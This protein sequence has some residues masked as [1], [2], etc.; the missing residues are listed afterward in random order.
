MAGQNKNG[1][2]LHIWF[3]EYN[4]TMA[5]HPLFKQP[6]DTH[7]FEQIRL[8]TE[9]MVNVNTYLPVLQQKSMEESGSPYNPELQASLLE[10]A[11]LAQHSMPTMRECQTAAELQI[12][13]VA[14]LELQSV[15]THLRK[16]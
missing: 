3:E 5:T 14:I 15:V 7:M 16:A 4:H 6:L 10:F 8:L 9:W 1:V 13:R 2:P 12:R 11:E